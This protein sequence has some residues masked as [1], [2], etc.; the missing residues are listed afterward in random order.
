MKRSVLRLKTDQFGC[1]TEFSEH[2]GRICASNA[3]AL[4][5]SVRPS[6]HIAIGV[7]VCSPTPHTTTPSLTV[8]ADQ[9]GVSAQRGAS[10]KH[11]SERAILVRETKAPPA[12]SLDGSPS[13][14]EA[15][16]LASSGG[17]GR[18]AVAAF[19]ASHAL[20]G[21]GAPGAQ[22]PLSTPSVWTT[23]F[24]S[25][26]LPPSRALPRATPG[27]AGCAKRGWRRTS[28][29]RRLAATRPSGDSAERRPSLPGVAR[30]LS[31]T[32]TSAANTRARR[33]RRA[34]IFARLGPGSWPGA[35]LGR[36]VPTGSLNA[37]PGDRN[38]QRP[39]GV[40]WWPRAAGAARPTENARLNA[41]LHRAQG[42][43]N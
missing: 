41:C 35:A 33:G 19:T 22:A 23:D 11:V 27:C 9:L 24:A 10:T 43:A 15:C 2:I 6:L 39:T 13:R 8:F 37:C 38:G 28:L 32:A 21:R 18:H 7:D 20:N 5:S 4:A 42:C 29:G 16:G 12:A 1:R 36:R 40:G 25:I 3:T 14:E 34:L 30:G 26:H 31:A 17:A